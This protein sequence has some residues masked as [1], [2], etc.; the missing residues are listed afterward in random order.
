MINKFKVL[1]YQSD[2]INEFLGAIDWNEKSD[3]SLEIKTNYLCDNIQKCVDKFTK[4]CSVNNKF[5]NKWY[6]AELAN[7][8]DKLDLLHKRAVYTDGKQDWLMYRTERNSYSK[9]I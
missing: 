4:E 6:T 5:Q 8:R 7:M 3:H 2:D 9:K 1:K